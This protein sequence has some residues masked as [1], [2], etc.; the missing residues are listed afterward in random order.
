MMRGS[1]ASLAPDVRLPVRDRV[2]VSAVYRL[3]RH[4]RIGSLVVDLPDGTSWRLAG[5]N[6]ERRVRVTVN[7]WTF[8]RR[9]LLG[10]DVGLGES[11]VAGEWQC[12]DLVELFR[13]VL[14]H[15]AIARRRAPLAALQ[16]FTNAWRPRHVVDDVRAHYDL[17]N[18]LFALF[19][20]ESMTYSA[21]VFPTATTDL[22]DAQRNKLDAICRRV[23]L[24]P[25]LSVLDIGGGWGSFALHAAGAY[26]CRVLSITLSEAQH[27]LARERVRRAGL[28][29]K[30][31]VRLCDYREVRG[32]FDRIVSIEMFEAVGYRSW[33]TFFRTCERLLAPGGS[34]FLQTTVYPDRDFRA[35]RRN[36]DWLR[37]HVFPGYAARIAASDRTHPRH[38][39]GLADPV[40]GGHRAALC[41][42][43]PL[44]ARALSPEPPGGPPSRIRR[45]VHPQVGSVPRHLRSG[46][47]RPSSRNAAAADRFRAGAGHSHVMRVAVVGTGV[48]GMVAA[49]LLCRSHDVVVFEAN[50]WIGGHAHTVSVDLAGATYDVDTGF[51]VYNEPTYPSFSK[52]L[53]R[54]GVRT[55]PTDMSF[56][57]RCEATGFEYSGGSVAGLFAQPRNLFR[58]G[59]HRL[60]R[61][62]L[63][64]NREAPALLDG[65]PRRP[66]DR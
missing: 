7:T 18:E 25:G 27:A 24:G 59:F 9:I 14:Q 2:A 64:F 56:S 30:V 58:P 12:D 40:D 8:F 51:V 37:L 36:V 38:R 5:E 61:D 66:V 19:L 63:R 45:C 57:V 65:R 62:I 55:Q 20:D 17:G 31:D 26:G 53:E 3:L 44:L 49:Y 41:R 22:A 48:S 32:Q 23:A 4:W 21:A 43:A 35:Y 34:M 50:D 60:L 42:D 28:E 11:Y 46:L 13:L 39:D 6:P 54:L 52:L 16:A 10:G 47:L 33:P 15:H 29:S 1:V